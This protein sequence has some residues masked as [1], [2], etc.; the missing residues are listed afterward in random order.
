MRI[1]VDF[2]DVL[3]ETALALAALARE[4]FGRDVPY[5][6][7]H[8]FDLRVAFDL[9]DGDYLALM[10][11]A[12]EPGFLRGL[13]VTPG[14]ADCL[15]AWKRQGHEV[16]V[17]TGRPASCH[18]SSREWL[19]REGLDFLPVLYA[20][21]YQRAYAPSA[22]DPCVLTLEELARERFDLAIEDS[23]V[24]LDRLLDRP[25]CEVVV[26]D[27]PW[28]RRYSH[29]RR[30]PGRCADWSALDRIVQSMGGRPA[31]R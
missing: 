18:P 11:R 17:V 15:R 29:P 8:A 12:H 21:K 20:D 3:C 4:M 22:G 13:T 10:D 6:R 9:G 31:G 30:T 24:A 27:R 1:Y 28:N 5:E 26:F 23:P 7:I 25:A 19:L 2:D 16:V 14:C